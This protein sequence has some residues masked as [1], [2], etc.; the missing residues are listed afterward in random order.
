M[1]SQ[2]D[3]F[4]REG[5]QKLKDWAL[6]EHLANGSHK[7]GVGDIP[8]RNTYFLAFGG[9]VQGNIWVLN[10]AGNYRLQVYDAFSWH[11]VSV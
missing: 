2:L 10:E 5:R 1:V 6:V 8:A 11:F 7:I 3:N 4:E 9:P